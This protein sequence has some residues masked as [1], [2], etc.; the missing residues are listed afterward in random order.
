MSL[1]VICGAT[2][3]GKS[4]LA[5]ALAREIN[6]EVVNA[7]SMQVYK[8]MDIGT[9]K[10]T[11][12]QRDAVAHHLIDVLDITEE[13]NVS[14]YQQVAR[15]KIDELITSGKSVVV[16]GGCLLYTSDAADEEDSVDLGGRRIIK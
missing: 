11:I 3:T 2:A 6:A 16:V 5:V 9:A 15:D 1:T 7:D 12:V 8:G 14:W 10:L 4:E 13:A